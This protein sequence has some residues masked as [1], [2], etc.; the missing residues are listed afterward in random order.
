MY[1]E[2]W[3]V[4]VREVM[5]NVGK[6][7]EERELDSVVRLISRSPGIKRSQV[8]QYFHFNAR[9]ADNVFNTLEQRGLVRRQKVGRTEQLWV[10]E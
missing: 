7:S 2:Q 9:Q 6:G 3:R 10:I 8:M 5:K 4:H 1:G